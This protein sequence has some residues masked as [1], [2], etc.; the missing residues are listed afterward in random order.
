V[1]R[2]RRL[3]DER[4]GPALALDAA[5]YRLDPGDHGV[6]LDRFERLA[7]EGTALLAAGRVTEAG[8]ALAAA[9]AL[10]RVSRSWSWWSMGRRAPRRRRW[11]SGG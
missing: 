6:D 5:G 11:R 9:L 10:W 7:E 2:L 3:L 4:G 8:E 1:S